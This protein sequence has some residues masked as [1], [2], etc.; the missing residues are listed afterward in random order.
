MAIKTIVI[1]EVIA[2]FCCQKQTKLV[3]KSSRCCILAMQSE[4]RRI[5]FLAFSLQSNN[6]HT[7]ELEGKAQ[8]SIFQVSLFYIILS[9]LAQTLFPKF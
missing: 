3:A 4:S 7:L 1:E 5:T 8:I 9:S 2:L 6:G